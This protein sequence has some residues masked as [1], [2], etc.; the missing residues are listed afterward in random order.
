MLHQDTYIVVLGS[1]A[2]SERKE[3]RMAKTLEQWVSR[4]FAPMACYGGEV[5]YASIQGFEQVWPLDWIAGS[6]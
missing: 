1:V 5:F 4:F 3:A 2:G 6:I